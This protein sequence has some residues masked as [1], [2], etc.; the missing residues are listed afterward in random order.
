MADTDTD[1]SVEWLLT[2]D[3]PEER[4]QTRIEAELL[5][6][7]RSLPPALQEALLASAKAMEKT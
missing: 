4:A 3:A 7:C 1:A 2:G 5:R 6:A